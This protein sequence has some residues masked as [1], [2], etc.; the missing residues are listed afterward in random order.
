[1]ELVS[2]PL[3]LVEFIEVVVDSVSTHDLMRDV[4]TQHDVVL[5]LQDGGDEP[6]PQVQPSTGK[7]ERGKEG[8]REK[9]REEREGGRERERGRREGKGKRKEEGRERERKEG[10]REGEREGTIERKNKVLLIMRTTIYTGRD[11]LP[12]AIGGVIKA[13]SDWA[14]QE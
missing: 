5:I 7:G 6:W 11:N 9:R 4:G 10:G 14:P 8:G 2:V 1:M 13:P 12:E 3:R